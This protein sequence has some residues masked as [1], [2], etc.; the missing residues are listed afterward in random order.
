[1]NQ[2]FIPG[3]PLFTR[4]NDTNEWL[5]LALVSWGP[6]AEDQSETSYDVNVDLLHFHPWLAEKRTN[7]GFVCYNMQIRNDFNWIIHFFNSK[8]LVAFSLELSAM[9]SV[10]YYDKTLLG[11]RL[12]Y[13]LVLGLRY[14]LGYWSSLAVGL[15][16]GLGYVQGYGLGCWLGH[17]LGFVAINYG[18]RQL[19]LI[20]LY[21]LFILHNEANTINII[22]WKDFLERFRLRILSNKR[23]YKVWRSTLNLCTRTPLIPANTFNLV[24][25]HTSFKIL[26]FCLK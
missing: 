2:I 22:G 26:T 17:W 7:S 1:M 23:R 18:K 11:Y 3:G 6:T 5:Q 19:F 14:G 21:G 16:Y 10:L 15:G 20:L 12:G 24:S 4:N 25:V 8:A 9:V 13:S